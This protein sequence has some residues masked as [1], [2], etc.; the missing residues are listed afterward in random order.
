MGVRRTMH[1]VK[2]ETTASWTVL[3]FL[4]VVFAAFAACSIAYRHDVRGQL[5]RIVQIRGDAARRHACQQR[6]KADPLSMVEF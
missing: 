3:G 2:I 4:S 1:F 6:L 5:T